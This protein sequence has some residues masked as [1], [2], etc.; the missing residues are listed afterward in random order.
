MIINVTTE[1]YCNVILSFS[2]VSP[3]VCK[4]RER[5]N[6]N[7]FF[8]AHTQRS[9][10]AGRHVSPSVSIESKGETRS[11]EHYGGRKSVGLKVASLKSFAGYEVVMEKG[12]SFS[13]LRNVILITSETSNTNVCVSCL[14]TV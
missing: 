3:C 7:V 14:E 8:Q 9:G 6:F 12:K 10:E 11:N 4:T 5:V 13:L 2:C 1:T